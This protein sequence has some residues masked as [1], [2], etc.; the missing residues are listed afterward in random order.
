MKA[1]LDILRLVWPLALGMVNN[2]VMQSVDRAYLARSSMECLEA[3]LPATALAWLFLGFFQSVVGYAGVFVAQYHGAGSRAACVKSYRVALALAGAA[4]ALML[5]IAMWGGRLLG[6]TGASAGVVDLA[7]GYFRVAAFG[8]VFVFGHIAASSF[9]TGMGRTRIVFWVNLA[10]N[11]LNILLDPLFIFGE[12]SCGEFSIPC[13]GLG[14]KGAAYATVIS[15]AV[16]LA[17]LAIAARRVTRTV[18]KDDADVPSAW[19]LAKRVL[20]F[21]LASGGYEVLN[22]LSFT[23][24]VFVTGGVGGLELAVSNTC[25]TVNFLLFAPMIGFSVGAQTL[26]GQA[27]GRGDPAEAA[28]AVRR[29]MILGLAFVATLATV[30]LL[31]HRPILSFYAPSDP[32]ARSQFI[33]LGFRLMT[34]M[35]TWLL[36]DSADMIYSGALKGAG[37]T[38]FVFWWMLVCSFAI[39]M[40]LVFM[41]RQFFNT[42]PALW[43]TMVAYVVVICA[44]SAIRW[45][46]G[47]WKTHRLV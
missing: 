5:P 22:M 7:E 29:T 8:G 31:L 4:G 13:L 45:R 38:R 39:W 34:L 19:E 23:I 42:M 3:V 16:Q 17:A 33:S 41:A 43:S 9:F 18:G 14:M 15:Q 20:R 47:R 11:L 12:L 1:Y 35:F 28:L 27:M 21:G 40:P 32:A 24:F 46:R 36:L 10:G 44:G 30:V 26:V 37:D 2:A 6:L 25:F